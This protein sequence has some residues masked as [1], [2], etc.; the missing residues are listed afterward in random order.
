MSTLKLQLLLGAVEKIT[1]PLKAI[2][3]QSKVTANDLKNTKQRIKELE[4]QTAQVDGYRTLGKQIGITR[5]QLS[6]AQNAAQQLGKKLSETQNPTKA[7]VREFERAKLVVRDLTAK[8]REMVAKHGQVK[9]AM[10]EAGISTKQLSS[11]QRTLKA[12]LASATAQYEKQRASIT[13]LADT[14][15]RLNQVKAN[16][17]HTQELRGQIAGHGAAAL[18]TGTAA[19]MTTLKP[20]IEFSK[21]ETAVTDLRVS[22]MGAKGLRKEFQQISDLATRLGNRLPGTSA[23]F[24]NMMSTLIQQGM[25]E[26]AILGGLGEATAYLGVQLKKPYN[27][28]ALFAAKLQDATGTAEKDMMGLM[29]TIQRSYYLGVDDS[30][31]LGAFSALTPA[32][33]ILRKAGLDAANT[34]AP[35]IIMAD[36]AALSGESAGNAYRKIFQMSMN[37]NK[38]QKATKGTGLSLNFTDG[39]GEFGGLEQMYAQLAKLKNLSTEK[40][41]QVLKDI[42]GDDK[43]TL[44]ALDIMI[45]K[46]ISGYRETQKKMA[47]QASLQ[48]RVNAQLGTMG[49]LWDAATGTF[50]N[51]LVNFGESVS[52]E[53]KAVIEWIGNLSERLANWS[54][55]N[56]ELSRTIMRVA[57]LV[58][59]VTIAFGA[60]SLTIAAILGPMAIM[61]L[62]MSV[63]GI[64]ASLLGLTFGKLAGAIQ[65]VGSAIVWA[66][67]A[68]M[69]NPII[70]AAALLA[71]AVYLIY[72]NWD[73]LVPW[74][75][76]VWDQCKGPVLAFWNVLKEV[77]S[78]T[79]IGLLTSH[80]GAIW[81]F[82]DTLPEG[83][84]NKGRAIVSGLIDGITAK[85]RDLM[86]AV[87]SLTKYLPDWVTGGGVTISQ[88]NI[89]GP[90][91]L[92]GNGGSGLAMAGSGYMPKMYT[93]KP[94][95]Q[96]AVNN[97]VSVSAPI[98]IQ[99]QPG[100]SATSVAQEVSRQLDDRERRARAASR[101]SLGDT[102]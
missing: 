33:S 22:M 23:D 62:S 68:L 50:T 80:W 51:A 34:L 86:D 97:S 88:E 19:G 2:S 64:K 89:S 95:A 60:L 69:T 71:G 55:Q 31:M 20:V 43:E 99:Q 65:F 27:E 81:S 61:K 25:T 85:W 83:A 52:P 74:F 32:L 4:N 36:Q 9:R 93:P 26:K 40:R 72:K 28:A 38:I 47:D 1:A 58:S 57:A 24:Q 98:Y 46:G 41:L 63:L 67:R 14:Q 84:M 21:A 79:P 16:Y 92:T 73:T 29:D 13:K 5:S 77:S 35:L 70:A 91:Y 39:K 59:V 76:S 11:Y 44:Q 53:V 3:G 49:N 78:W 10:N 90:N 12:D 7:M 8:E 54:K 17:R 94:L 30:N 96:K 45:K 42:Y 15:K 87:K 100:Q 82:F 37:T 18:A 75:K 101:A 56:P 48:E 6:Q 66:A 102:H